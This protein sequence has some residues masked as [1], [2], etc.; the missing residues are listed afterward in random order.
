MA[1][2]SADGLGT[3]LRRLLELLDGDLETV[4]RADHPFYVP[5]YTPVMKALAAHE[6]LTIKDI[7]A[8]SSV[9]HSAASQTVTKLTQHGLAALTRHDDGRSRVVRLTGA[10]RD[11]LPWLEMRWAATGK[12]AAALERELD[13]PL[14]KLLQQAIDRLEDKS[15]STRIRS[16]DDQKDSQT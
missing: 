15:F 6:H 4:Y 13:Y 5:R 8:M 1:N 7:A 3:Q 12:A 2:K 9:S 16:Y 14:G 11:L 10:G